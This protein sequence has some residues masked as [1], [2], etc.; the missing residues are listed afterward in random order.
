MVGNILGFLIML[1]SPGT[2]IRQEFFPPPPSIPRT[3]E[4]AISGYMG[5]WVDLFSS[6]GRITALVAIVLVSLWLG[7]TSEHKLTNGYLI[8]LSIASGILLS[9]VSVV[10]AVYATSDLPP[11]RLLVISSFIIVASFFYAGLMAGKW[12]PGNLIASVPVKFGLMWCVGIVI[13]F[14][15]LVNARILYDHREIY[16]SFAQRWDQA[17]AQIMQ[18]KRN[19]EESVTIPALNVWTGPGGDP[20]DNPRYWVTACYRL[21][22]DFPVF[23]PALNFENP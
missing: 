5:F 7:T 4:I 16:I 13:V 12:I 14:S 2:E 17:D 6:P 18:A 15:T 21:Y 20:T 22:Y 9:F 3:L 23:G 19:G 11:S 1:S 10:P 8:L